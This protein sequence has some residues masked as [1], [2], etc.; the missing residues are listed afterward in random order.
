MYLVMKHFDMDD[1]PILLTSSKRKAEQLQVCWKFQIDHHNVLATEEEQSL[2]GADIGSHLIAVSITEFR[3][4]RPVNMN[5][6]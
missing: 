6:E 4:G 3:Q 1:I 2:V 5:K